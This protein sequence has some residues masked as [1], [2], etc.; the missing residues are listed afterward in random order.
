MAQ[1]FIASCP[2]EGIEE[3]IQDQQTI[4]CSTDN[5]NGLHSLDIVEILKGE[6]QYDEVNT[7]DQDHTPHEFS[8]T[9][10][11]G[12]QDGMYVIP[13]YRVNDDSRVFYSNNSLAGHVHNSVS[14]TDSTI[15]PWRLRKAEAE[16]FWYIELSNGRF[17]RRSGNRLIPFALT[18]CSTRE[19]ATPWII[20]DVVT[21]LN[22]WTIHTDIKHTTDFYGITCNPNNELTISLNSLDSFSFFVSQINLTFHAEGKVWNTYTSLRGGAFTLPNY[23]GTHEGATFIGWNTIENQVEGYLPPGTVIETNETDYY[24]VFVRSE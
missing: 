21:P 24:A 19:Q 17:L 23:T 15:S 7:L 16:G 8:V 13:S 10:F 11:N 6:Y 2:D 3:I 4:I 18:T 5:C 20:K 12:L 14:I 1:Q 9:I 22:F